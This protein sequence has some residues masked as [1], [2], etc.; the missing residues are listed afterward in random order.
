M[1][2]LG[3]FVA[4]F[5]L[6]GSAIWSRESNIGLNKNTVYAGELLLLLIVENI[7]LLALGCIGPSIELLIIKY[8]EIEFTFKQLRLFMGYHYIVILIIIQIFLIISFIISFLILSYYRVI[9]VEYDKYF[10]IVSIFLMSLGAYLLF[11]VLM[12]YHGNSVLII[13]FF[14]KINSCLKEMIKSSKKGVKKLSRKNPL[15]STRS[16]NITFSLVIDV[17]FKLCEIFKLMI[18]NLSIPLFCMNHVYIMGTS[19]LAYCYMHGITYEAEI[20]WHIIYATNL[21]A[22]TILTTI[23]KKMVSRNQNYY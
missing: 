13:I 12:I 8:R 20:Y 7:N 4:T 22:L 10:S 23:L 1:F 14:Y 18:S 6:F 3:Y 11:L 19:L 16:D 21:M 5:S 9:M 2:V 15:F 17:H